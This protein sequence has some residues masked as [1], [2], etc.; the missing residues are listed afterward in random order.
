MTSPNRARIVATRHL[1]AAGHYLAA[2]AG[3]QI[4]EGGG[5]AVDAACAGGIALGIL[6]SEYVGFGGVAP[7]MVRLAESGEVF[8][9]SG[10]GWWPKAADVNFF[11]DKHG[12]RMP[13]SLRRTVIPAAPD[14]WITALERWGT[15]SFGEAAAAAIRFARDGFPMTHLS[16]RLIAENAD[17]YRRWP[18]NAALYLPGGQP[19]REG[20]LFRLPD[21]A[22]TM[23]Y[24]ADE[25]KA[26]GGD[27]L[28]GLGRARDAFYKGD[29]AKRIAAYHR[30]HD[31]WV[32]EEDMASFRV[33]VETASKVQLNGFT[34]H[35]CG[36][37]CQ[38]PALLETLN[39]L[40]G[41]DLK[42]MGH[43]SPAYLHT[44]LEALK[45]AFA[46]RHQWV[47]DPRYFKVPLDGLLSKAF[48]ARRRAMID[49][50]RAWPDM[51]PAGSAAD[52][53]AV[54]GPS[55]PVG[56]REG[57]YA[58]EQLDT[59]Y[60][61]VVDRWGNAVSATPSDGSFSAPAIPGLG[62]VPSSRG[63]QNWTNADAPAVMAPGKRPRLTPNPAIAVG[64][65]G[66]WVMPC[67]SPGNDVQ[68]QAMT[69]VL[70]NI[71]LFGMAPQD[72]VEAPRA[73]TVSYP[74][75]SD[76]HE[77][78]PGRINLERRLPDST[79]DALAALG[80]EVKW[81][82]EWDYRAGA[83]CCVL[84]DRDKGMIEGGAD[85]RRP[86]GISGL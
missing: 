47:A 13:P 5:N 18:Q 52:L 62:F 26:A 3:L 56:R 27:R 4:L 21:L 55:A 11:R 84:A 33:E 53:A 63:T 54:A 24:M 60:C 75:S 19:P 25:E 65:D 49:P 41:C 8:T 1:V 79:A 6:Q 2:Q 38:G 30:E 10:V 7:I 32:T 20:E 59:S 39:I 28:A 85:P 40:D 57:T 64:P 15:I 81:W 68:I 43:N 72:A 71:T 12:G 37:W 70:L 50:K 61:A 44:I 16:A 35:G 46:D 73:A 34:L 23:Q 80:H 58:D 69:Q 74:R 83:V 42:A 77:Y 45:L 82:E 48:A 9:V 66:R 36:P 86:T 31:G 51:P 29:I 17:G 67:G 76:P 14:A 22:A 78:H